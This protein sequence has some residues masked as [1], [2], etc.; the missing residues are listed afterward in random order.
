[1]SVARTLPE[2][3]NVQL[4]IELLHFNE[5]RLRPTIGS[6]DVRGDVEREARLR[7]VEEEFVEACRR[8]VAPIAAEAPSDPEGFLAWFC[9]LREI[10]PGQHDPL[11]NWLA[12]HATIQQLRWFLTQEVAGEAG[13]D[14]LVAMTQIKMPTQAKLELAR[15]YWD[16]MGRGT[17]IAM[18]GPMLSRLAQSLELVVVNEE[19]VPEAL[20]LGNLLVAFAANR[21]YAY[22][23]VG[24]LGAVELTAPDRSQL[25]NAALKRL[26]V[27]GKDRQYFALHAT[28][29]VQHSIAWNR[30][31]IGPL[32]AEEPRCARAIAEGALMRL[33]AGQLCFERYRKD[34]GV[35]PAA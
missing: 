5:W 24:A 13:F 15:N 10:G 22:H 32:V 33:R 1:V 23:S 8:D 2:A 34:L 27:P 9:R 4:Q 11:F 19:I 7:L 3:S 29:D 6:E 16:E 25:V 12:D 30:E 18:H 17:E 21:R 31:V 35:R 28:L 26:R 14:D 20:A